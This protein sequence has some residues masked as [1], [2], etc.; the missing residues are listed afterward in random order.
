MRVSSSPTMALIASMWI[1]IIRAR[2]A[3]CSA[4]RPASASARA[5]ILTRSRPRASSGPGVTFAGDQRLE[6]RPTGLAEQITDHDGELDAGVFEQL[7]HAL[8]FTAAVAEQ[9]AAP[10]GEIAQPADRRRRHEAGPHQPVRDQV[11]DP[12]GVG[13]IR[14]AAGD[15]ADVPGVEQPALEAL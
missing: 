7:L 10:T 11:T 12:L 5:G 4:K 8:L 1:R 13:H 6:H 14:L 2:K 9:D 15:P 3:W